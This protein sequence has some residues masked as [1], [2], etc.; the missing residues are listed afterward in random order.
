[1]SI[2]KCPSVY[3]LTK[4]NVWN[5]SVSD[6]PLADEDGLDLI[7]NNSFIMNVQQKHENSHK[8]AQTA[9]QRKRE[10]DYRDVHNNHI[11]KRCANKDITQQHNDAE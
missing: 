1:M 9:E 2:C 10:H 3:E 5:G 11:H 6:R 4:M 7:N 8:D